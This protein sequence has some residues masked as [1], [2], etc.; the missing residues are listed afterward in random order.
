MNAAIRWLADFVRG[1]TGEWPDRGDRLRVLAIAAVIVISS[2]AT[3]VYGY[4]QGL[5]TGEQIYQCLA[6]LLFIAAA[7]GLYYRSKA[8]Y[9]GAYIFSLV[10]MASLAMPTVWLPVFAVL[11]W[12]GQNSAPISAMAIVEAWSILWTA[13]FVYAALRFIEF[14]GWLR[15]IGTKFGAALSGLIIVGGIFLVVWSAIDMSVGNSFVQAWM[16]DPEYYAAIRLGLV[17]LL[18]PP[19]FAYAWWSYATLRSRA[20]RDAFGL[21]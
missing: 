2:A 19:I 8:A 9:I 14:Y 16:T 3:I 7:V 6:A 13:F 10:L 17:A 4:R 12:N 15:R 18:T 21:P 11:A 5:L 20:V 1:R